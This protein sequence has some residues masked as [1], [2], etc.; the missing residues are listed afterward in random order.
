MAVNWKNLK[1][2]KP[3][4][5]LARIAAIR[6]RSPDGKGSSF[7]GWELDQSM[8]LLHSMIEFPPIA[9]DMD[10]ATLIWKAVAFDPDELSRQSFMKELNRQ[11]DIELAQR[12]EVFHV[13]TSVSINSRIQL[14]TV[15]IGGVQIR[16]CGKEFPRKFPQHRSTSIQEARL[17]VVESPSSY[18]KLIATVTAKKPALALTAAIRAVDIHRAVWCLFS[19]AEMEMIGKS[20]NPINAVRLGAIH[21]VHS[22]DGHSAHGTVWFEPHHIQSTPYEH[23]DIEAIKKQVLGT[24]RRLRQCPYRDDIADALL[25][26]VR[27]LDE[28][29][30]ST[31]FTRLWSAVERLASPGYGDYDA[32]VR[33]CAFLWRDNAFATQAL[34][35]FRE[36][37]NA[38]AH[39]G[40]EST[41]AKTYCFQLQQ[42]FRPLLFFHITNAR[43]FQT[44]AEANE[45]L[46]MPTNMGVLEKLKQRVARAISFQTPR[47]KT[48]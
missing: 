36:Y 21:T 14:G 32:I 44:L 25:L 41:E 37:R 47:P 42:Y 18:Q 23:R 27:A 10:H 34:E 4:I 38:Y 28:S 15:T 39:G 40:S 3:D 6:T 5:V 29:N 12:Q 17:P 8:P 26:Y 35:H 13:L 22:Q 16:F 46:D 9:R 45:F 48:T 43:R 7:S 2:F 20:W 30:Q 1:R 11:L 24:L 33:R 31:A 19:N